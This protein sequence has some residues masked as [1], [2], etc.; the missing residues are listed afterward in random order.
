LIARVGINKDAPD[1]PLD[2]AGVTRSTQFRGTGLLW[3]DGNIAF[4]GGAGTG[5]SINSISGGNNFMQINFKSGTT[6]TAGADIFTAT[7][8]LGVSALTYPVFSQRSN[9]NLSDVMGALYIRSGAANTFILAI[10]AGVS[11]P[12]TTDCCLNFLWFGY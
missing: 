11:I 4:H 3:A 9:A 1:H 8:P 7:Y 10:K 12:A 5:P 6:P 2:V